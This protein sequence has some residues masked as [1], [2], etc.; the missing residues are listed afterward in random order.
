MIQLRDKKDGRVFGSV[1]AAQLQFLFNQLEKDT[2]ANTEY[3]LNKAT[4]EMLMDRGADQEL[5]ATLHTA[6]G[7]QDTVE[8]ECVPLPEGHLEAREAS[9]DAGE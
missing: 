2:G 4:L 3:R 1:T 5:V 6:L 7:S 9:I 8:V